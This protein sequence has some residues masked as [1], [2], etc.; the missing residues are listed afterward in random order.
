MKNKFSQIVY[1]AN[2]FDRRYIQFVYFVFLL[3]G[4][5]IARAPYD[6]GGGPI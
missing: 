2:K 1:F 6:G 4:F 5:L 3:A